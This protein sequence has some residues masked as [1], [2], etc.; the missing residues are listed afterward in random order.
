MNY[1]NRNATIPYTNRDFMQAYLLA[2]GV[3]VGLALGSRSIFA[4]HIKS[5][6]GPR[7]FLTNALLNYLSAAFAGA[8]NLF[9]MRSKELT[10]GI[11]LQNK[12][13]TENYGESKLAAKKAIQ[14]TALSRFI[15]PFPVIFFPALIQ[16]LLTTLTLWPRKIWLAK[17]LE[18]SLCAISLTYAL[19]ASVALF[20]NRGKLT[21]A[22][23]EE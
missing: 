13:G 21:N 17:L 2:T 8:S 10:S 18:I 3:S 20:P 11:Q 23:V 1:G 12:D 7:L 4:S 19:P 6:R 22:E 16:S 9:F 5:L 14:Q 15:L